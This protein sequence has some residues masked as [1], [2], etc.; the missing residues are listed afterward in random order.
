MLVDTTDPVGG[1]V[2]DGSNPAQD[3]NIT[4]D[5]NVVAATWNG[6]SDPDSGIARYKVEVKTQGKEE[7]FSK[8]VGS[9]S[10]PSSS[11]GF[12]WTHIHFD[13]GDRVLVSVT[14]V[15]GAEQ[16]VTRQSDG[17]LV[18]TTPPLLVYLRDGLDAIE[19]VQYQTNR[20]QANAIWELVDVE[21]GVEYHEVSLLQLKS[22]SRMRV[23]PP[24]TLDGPIA[25]RLAGNATSWTKTS[26]E[27]VSGGKYIVTVTAVNKAGLMATHETDGFIV[28]DFPPQ[29]L[30][31]DVLPSG[32]DA[33]DVLVDDRGNIVISSTDT[34]QCRW[35]GFDDETKIV[36]YLLDVVEDPGNVSV[37]TNG[38]FVSMGL[39]TTAI[40]DGLNLTIGDSVFGPFYRVY[41]KAV[42]AS[43]NVSP[44]M[45]SKRIRYVRSII[46]MFLHA[47]FKLFDF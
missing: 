17:F 10:L 47:I 9:D 1:I 11:D 32:Q 38:M 41:V 6:F 39:R 25:E 5:S 12:E 35:S 26:L 7:A 8:V 27:L 28:D 29:V 2:Q 20:S 37:T 42:D 36:E 43:G 45:K 31:V 13:D 24:V 18:D 15:N 46:K 19:D 44:E 33:S 40:V 30:S 16:Q 22:G 4:S 34:I 3:V 21:S 14:A 23:W